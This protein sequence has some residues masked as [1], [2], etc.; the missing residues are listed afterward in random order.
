MTAHRPARRLAAADLD[1]TR[2]NSIGRLACAASR[3]SASTRATNFG[4]RRAQTSD[5]QTSGRINHRRSS[6]VPLRQPA[7]LVTGRP[8]GSSALSAR[9]K[10]AS[11]CAS[12]E[13]A[14]LLDRLPDFGGL[15]S[16]ARRDP[17]PERPGCGVARFARAP[18]RHAKLG[19]QLACRSSR[20]SRSRSADNLAVRVWRDMREHVTLTVR[21]VD[22]TAD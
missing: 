12:M 8:S 15:K 20:P 18:A 5:F 13:M 6:P 11:P 3:A 17:L 1:Q 9:S 14:D 10:R 4:S 19:R 22:E 21:H 16:A 2:C 7:R